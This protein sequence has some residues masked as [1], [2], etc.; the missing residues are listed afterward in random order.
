MSDTE[1]IVNRIG[2]LLARQPLVDGVRTLTI[3]SYT[4]T[5]VEG[6]PWSTS[7]RPLA[8]LAQVSQQERDAFVDDLTRQWLAAV[9]AVPA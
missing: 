7:N 5:A 1:L 6:M 9:S 3:R 2:H 4:F 8:E